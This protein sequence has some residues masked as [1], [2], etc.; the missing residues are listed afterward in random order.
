M[1]LNSSHHAPTSRQRMLRDMERERKQSNDD[2]IT[3]WA[4]IWT[5]FFFKIGTIAIIVYAA[6]GSAESWGIVL[7]TSWFWLWIPVIALS[8][9]VGWRW[10]LI[11]ARRM[12]RR[13]QAQE[14]SG[15][16]FGWSD[17]HHALTSEERSRLEHLKQQRRREDA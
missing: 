4:V 7:F 15:A 14:F 17:T 13:F 8:G 2:K 5:L 16:P 11:K 10:R 1:P 3:G 6:R 12:R 9:F